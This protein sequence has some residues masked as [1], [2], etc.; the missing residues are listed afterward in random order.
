MLISNSDAKK[1]DKPATPGLLLYISSI[2]VTVA[3]SMQLFGVTYPSLTDLPN[4]LAR[5]AIQ[6]GGEVA[7]NY[8][9]Y[10][11]FQLRALP[12]LA[13]DLFYTF[14]IACRDVFLSNR[15]LI[16]FTILNLIA[17]VYFLHFVIWRKLSVWPAAS[18]L[19]V[20]NTNF[21]YGFENFA[22][23]TPFTLYLY[24]LWILMSEKPAIARLALI[25]PL[26]LGLYFLHIVA[27]GFFILLIAGWEINRA[28]TNNTEGTFS[29]RRFLQ[30]LS[31]TVTLG[32]PALVHFVILNQSV[33][34][35]IDG[36]LFG[37]FNRFHALL[38]ITMPQHANLLKVEDM[39]LP[40]FTLQILAILA[41]IG[42]KRGHLHL[43]SKIRWAL[44]VPLLAAIIAPVIF[45]GFEFMHIRYPFLVAAVF[46]AATDWDIS[47]KQSGVLVLV[48][49]S[50]FAIR[51][52]ETH[53]D[54]SQHDTEVRE[55]LSAASSLPDGARILRTTNTKT[56]L[57]LRHAHT[58]SYFG[59]RYKIFTPSLFT[60][61]NPL[62][63]NRQV[64]TIV[65][66]QMLIM[67]LYPTLAHIRAFNEQTAS[68]ATTGE[69]WAQFYTHILVL[70]VPPVTESYLDENIRIVARG[71]YFTILE[72][73]VE[74]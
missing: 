14:D 27:F 60:G 67:P 18:S 29:W 59:L 12:N 39:I 70:G 41:F 45:L 2:V 21:A 28:I 48:L 9:G 65:R 43:S 26:S 61:T 4:H 24:G 40:M 34:E 38:S 53:R 17:A 15:V 69:D 58:A 8:S 20:Y 54:W 30:R 56:G 31:G 3:I 1:T 36:T 25:A 66:E 51:T 19:L 74:P 57:V 37:L 44:L 13:A 42:Y 33:G 32:V 55:L 7:D 22:L 5:H 49:L 62:M 10:Y 64:D 11:D 63:P 72:T 68:P 73:G 71:S 23:T 6:C 47:R 52:V 35:R 16:Q 50:L 46:I